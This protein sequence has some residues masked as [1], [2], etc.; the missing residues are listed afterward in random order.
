M[1]N[2]FRNVSYDNFDYY[3]ALNEEFNNIECKYIYL[4]IKKIII[5]TYIHTYITAKQFLTFWET[6]FV[7]VLFVLIT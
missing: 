3:M 7:N 5:N 6:F 4:F 2:N 1:N